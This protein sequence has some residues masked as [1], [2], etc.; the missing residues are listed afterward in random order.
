MNNK[1]EDYKISSHCDRLLQDLPA[2]LEA[3]QDK[4]GYYFDNKDLLIE[5]LSHPS[6]GHRNLKKIFQNSYE[7][8]EFLGDAV[9][10]LLITE[11][12][13]RRFRNFQE[14]KLA[15]IRSALV[16]R[17]TI[18]KVARKIDLPQYMIMSSG[19]DSSGGRTSLNNIENTMEA[20]VGAIYLDSNVDVAKKFVTD[21]W[22]EFIDNIDLADHDPKT[23]L[24]EFV[25]ARY[26][27]IPSYEL[28]K[29]EGSD[30]S[31]IFTVS[32][33]I[34]DNMVMG[35]GASLKEAEKDAARILLKIL[36]NKCL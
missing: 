9:L 36:Q 7:R 18:C 3:L 26:N 19:E 35:T 13:F 23:T 25:H 27:I 16:C 1:I 22:D 33:Q 28:V 12:L 6:L 20:L 2:K 5:A 21:L 31:V 30:H 34:H 32:L 29:K 17:D 4:I 8:L 24:Q 15:K 11:I 10:S 14:G